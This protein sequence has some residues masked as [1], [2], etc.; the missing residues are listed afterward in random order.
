MMVRGEWAWEVWRWVAKG[1]RTVGGRLDWK[2]GSCGD[3][4]ISLFSLQYGEGRG[5]LGFDGP[6][7][8]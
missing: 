4:G 6:H 2:V 1:A 5:Y 3:I 7:V 8:S